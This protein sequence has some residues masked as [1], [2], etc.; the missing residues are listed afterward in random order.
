MTL[1]MKQPERRQTPRTT[2]ERLAYIDIEPDNGGSVGNVSEGGLCFDSIA[3]VQRNTMIRLWFSECNQRIGVD[4]A[5]AWTDATQK[6]GGV[7]FTTL[8]AEAREQIRNLIRQ[9]R[10][11]VADEASTPSVQLPHGFPALSASRPD[12]KAPRASASIAVVSPQV[13]PPTPLSGFSRG[14]ATGLLISALVATVFL[15]HSY[16]RQF[17]E[18]L[19]QLG[20]RLTAKPQEQTQM[21]SPASQ[22]KLPPPQ[23]VYGVSVEVERRSPTRALIPAKRPDTVPPKPQTNPAK[24]QQA[25]RDPA[26]SA[27]VSS[28]P[29]TI[30]LP[31]TSVVPNSNLILGELGT[32]P[33]LVPANHPSGRTVDSREENAGSTSEMYFEIGKFKDEFWA[34]KATDQLAQL[35]F[36]ATVIEKGHL[37]M[38]SYY[39]LV[40]PYRD[41][42]GATEAHKRLVSRGFK[43]RAFERGSRTL[44][45]NGGCDAIGRLL[46]SGPT[47]RR[48]HTPVENCTIGWESYSAH[49]LVKFVQDNYVVATADGKWVKRGIRYERDAFVYRKNGDGSRTLIEIWFAGM[50]QALVF[51]K[52]S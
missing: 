1:R 41:D 32:T 52:S 35:G 25:R 15:L 10:L 22:T 7:R 9:P 11:L 21:M 51:G 30:S 5:L 17:G 26:G 42:E 24:P 23:A 3:P 39:A 14:L 2:I 27:A 33:Q 18:S 46:H 45:F 12:M 44:T 16:R 34:R 49:A 28:T 40:G 20:E 37:W 8:S 47:L 43:P 6:T 50:S 19:I 29:P 13:K 31:T 36:H 4:G 38:N 48:A